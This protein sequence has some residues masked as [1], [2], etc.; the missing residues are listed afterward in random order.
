MLD[1]E[2][3][4]KAVRVE[5]DNYGKTVQALKALAHELLWDDEGGV[6]VSEGGAH[7][8]RKMRTSAEN[9]VSPERDVTPDLVLMRSQIYGVV[10]EAKMSLPGKR[11]YRARELKKLA[12]YDDDLA[13]WDTPSGRIASHDLA[14]VVDLFISKDVRDDLVTLQQEGE[15][16]FDRALALI[17]FAIVNRAN[18]EVVAL[19]IVHGELSHEGKNAKLSRNLAIPLEYAAGNP[20]FAHVQLYD[21]RPPPPV[22]MELIHD[23]INADLTREERLVLRDEN[24]VKKQISVRALREELSCA[25]GP[26]E[27]GRGVPEIPK[28]AWVREAMRLFVKLGWAQADKDDRDSFTY[29]LKRRREPLR[30]FMALWVEELMRREKQ[31]EQDAR[32]MPLFRELVADEENHEDG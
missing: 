3:M 25:F 4:A 11:A 27:A 19:D 13:G 30:Q 6:C 5:C 17:S 15:L 24:E 29:T 21:H 16:C 9:R 23:T 22:L 32:D 8:G 28:A 18:G 31:R 26:G 7:F 10:A 1:A 12:K 14:L 20:L 2:E